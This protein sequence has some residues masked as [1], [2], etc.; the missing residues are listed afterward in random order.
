MCTSLPA[1]KATPTG[2]ARSGAMASVNPIGAR[3]PTNSPTASPRRFPPN[4]RPSRLDLPMPFRLFDAPLREP[5]QFVGFAGNDLD[6][7]SENRDEESLVKALTHP[8]ARLM[9][10]NG[11]RAYLKLKDGLFDPHFTPAE[12]VAF[13]ARL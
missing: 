7:Q 1:S 11:G 12:S 3:T 4:D 6:R 10:V 8:E 5:S 2:R 13:K 9:L